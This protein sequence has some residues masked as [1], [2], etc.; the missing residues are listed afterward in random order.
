MIITNNNHTNELK[1]LTKEI[2]KGTY[3][4]GAKQLRDNFI[5]IFSKKIPSIFKELSLEIES[6]SSAYGA[7]FDMGKGIMVN[8]LRQDKSEMTIKE[9]KENAA[10]IIDDLLENKVY[11]WV[12]RFLI[13]SKEL[14]LLSNEN[15][16][17][18][19]ER[20]KSET[21]HLSVTRWVFEEMVL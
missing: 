3:Q 13:F 12:N 10:K 18:Y 2:L 19:L 4:I 7:P 8:R 21:S 14:N 11:G 6:P 9:A 15:Y 20:V 17:H 1:V 16:N 5:T